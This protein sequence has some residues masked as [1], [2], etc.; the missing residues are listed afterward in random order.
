MR[1]TL[2]LLCVITLL[3][4]AGCAT[5]PP[6]AQRPDA[7][8]APSVDIA[9][10]TWRHLDEEIHDSAVTS[11]DLAARFARRQMEDWRER[12]LVR[13]ETHFIPWFSGFLTQQWLTAKVAWYR[14][15]SG[16]GD[17]PAEDRLAEYIQEQYYDRV[18]APVAKEVDP[19]AL[20]G[21][22]TKLFAQHMRQRLRLLREQHA[23]PEGQF[24]RRLKEIH[25]IRLES[26]ATPYAS[27]YDIANADPLDSVPA[28]AA[29][30][31]RIR[32]AG[33]R[34]GIGLSKNR[35]SP[36]ARH[37]SEQLMTQL[38]VRSGAGAIS[39]LMGKVAGSVLS[40]GASA[41][42]IAWHQANRE[43]IEIALRIT[44]DDAMNDMW[45]ILVDSPPSAVTTGI[46]HLFDQIEGSLPQTTTHPVPF[47]T[48]PAALE[49]PA[50]PN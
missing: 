11:R 49:L 31:A 21:Q 48:P 34:A 13:A 35:I 46:Y 16:D 50:P 25:A 37:V 33:I 19:V 40:I 32:E 42:G 17:L 38:A 20:V 36:V 8:A 39:T 26:S 12:A 43:D 4:L 44:L 30:L 47:E 9:E 45:A 29:L 7:P 23:I 15:S 2:R 1:S 22:S 24:S 27:L 3:A 14:L 41:L 6:L 5:R 28:Y 10:E 18:L